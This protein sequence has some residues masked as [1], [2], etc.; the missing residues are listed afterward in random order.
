MR[1]I[2]RFLVWLFRTI[3]RKLFGQWYKIYLNGM[4]I[5]SVKT[6]EERLEVEISPGQLEGGNGTG[7]LWIDPSPP[8]GTAIHVN[9]TT[10][11]DLQNAKSPT[12]PV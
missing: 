1:T 12:L 7:V 11:E 2:W 4:Y 8:G 5:A 6:K 3:K 10:Y 9:Y